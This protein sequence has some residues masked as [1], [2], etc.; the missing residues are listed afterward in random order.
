[1]Y[2]PSCCAHKHT[3]TVVCYVYICMY[4][5]YMC[6]SGK[7]ID[8]MRSCVV[9]IDG[10]IIRKGRPSIRVNIFLCVCVCLYIE[11]AAP[12]IQRADIMYYMKRF[13]AQCNCEKSM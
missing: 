9:F 10:K 13:Q 6:I 5:K 3:V 4:L 12:L 11:K 1:M 8:G 2:Y 7:N